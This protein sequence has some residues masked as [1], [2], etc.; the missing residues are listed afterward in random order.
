MS[1]IYKRSIGLIEATIE[2]NCKDHGVRGIL[3]H[4]DILRMVLEYNDEDKQARVFGRFQH[5]T[6][7]VYKMF[8]RKIHVI[9]PFAIDYKNYCVIERLDVHGRNPDAVSWVAIDRDGKKYIVDEMF[10]NVHGEAELATRIKAKAS[11]FRIID[12]RADP[13]AFNKDQHDSSQR[14]LADK[15]ELLGLRYLP[16]SKQRAIAIRRTMDAL[17]YIEQNGILIKEPELYVFDTCV[18]HIWEFEHWQYNEYTGKAAEKHNRSEKP[19]DK[20]DHMMENIGRALIDEIAFIP[21]RQY[22]DE[23]I[24]ETPT[25]DPYD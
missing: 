23:V 5:L 22:N 10:E 13:S 1:Q 14:S 3:D 18:R 2:D 7:L 20:D 17:N 21:Y 19:E 24:S 16:A 25:L 9:K 11:Q 8:S 12:R 4:N 6:G 15:L